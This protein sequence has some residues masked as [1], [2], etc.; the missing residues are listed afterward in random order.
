ME[1][2]EGFF[3][4]IFDTVFEYRVMEAV[5]N[6]AQHHRLPITKFYMGQ[7]RVKTENGFSVLRFTLD[8][9]IDLNEIARNEK[10]NKKIREEIIF[11]LRKNG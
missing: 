2:A 9:E 4:R 8:P 6:H 1:N 7:S 11:N 10:L 3:S 5:R